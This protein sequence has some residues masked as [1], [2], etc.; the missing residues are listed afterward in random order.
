MEIEAN[1]ALLLNSTDNFEHLD[2]DISEGENYM[3]DMMGEIHEQ[4]EQLM[5]DHGGRGPETAFEMWQAFT[6]AI[7]WSER[8]IQALLI[9][10]VT[11]FL[12][13]VILR[14]NENA[15]MSIFL[16]VCILVY[17]C[18]SVNT[19]CSLHWRD[20]STQNYFDERGVFA[21]VMYAAPLLVIG[22]LQL[23]RKSIYDADAS[24][25]GCL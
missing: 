17:F 9:F 22:L 18:E 15:Q 12:A 1:E 23:V 5:K 10:H 19:Y 20:F 13:A 25:N 14:N 24:H 7:N 6:S 4:M 11:L 3:G 21:S 16:T 2:I 8:W